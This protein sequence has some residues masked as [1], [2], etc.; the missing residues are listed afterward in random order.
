MNP[1][2]REVTDV[3]LAVLKDRYGPDFGEGRQLFTSDNPDAGGSTIH[4]DGRVERPALPIAWDTAVFVCPKCAHA[5]EEKHAITSGGWYCKY[6][7]T[8]FSDS[9]LEES[10]A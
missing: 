8:D 5:T 7:Y 9:D 3:E 4:P 1:T 6:C 10:A 2:I